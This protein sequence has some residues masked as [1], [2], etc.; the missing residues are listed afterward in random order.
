[1]RMHRKKALRKRLP[2]LFGVKENTL[3]QES[4][5]NKARDALKDLFPKMP[6]E[7][8]TEIIARAFEQ[9]TNKVGTA[10]E[11]P[12][13]RRV[14]LAV[15]A[16]IRHNYT[17]YDTLLRLGT[18]EE[19]REQVEKDCLDL[20]IDWR[21]DDETGELGF[22]EIFREV[23]YISS[24][25]ENDEHDEHD[26]HDESTDDDSDSDPDPE[27]DSSVNLVS[28]KVVTQ[29][30]HD[31]ATGT[32]H[33]AEA[34]NGLLEDDQPYIQDD[35][36]QGGR[37]YAVRAPLYRQQQVKSKVDRRGFHRYDARRQTRDSVDDIGNGTN[38][39]PIPHY[40]AHEPVTLGS[41][42][43]P[44]RTTVLPS[45]RSRQLLSRSSNQPS[46]ENHIPPLSD[47]VSNSNSHCEPFIF[48]QGRQGQAVA[49]QDH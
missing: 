46:N 37:R 33:E 47:R 5:D 24:D 23:I 40:T 22:E 14:Q 13:P 26:E 17:N 21:G 48:S 35:S 11:L 43:L 15:V 20:L 39:D 36:A 32:T 19:A 16:H 29:E 1:M 31:K 38:K 44:P 18:R 10:E 8:Q 9:G 41:R 3:S 42:P 2:A 45:P 25:D 27:H 30:L 34:G 6:E 4:L 12:L 49:E 7:D 28:S